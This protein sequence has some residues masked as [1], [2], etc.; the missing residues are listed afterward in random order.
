MARTRDPNPHDDERPIANQIADREA[1]DRE[2]EGWGNRYASGFESPAIERAWR[3]R[4]GI[5]SS[6]DGYYGPEH[7]DH[8]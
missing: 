2:A 8:D 6:C 4:H 3:Q 7:T 5:D 1:E